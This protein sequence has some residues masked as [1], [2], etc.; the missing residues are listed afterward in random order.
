[1]ESLLQAYFE[2]PTSQN[3]GAY[4]GFT[5][6]PEGERSAN[7]RALFLFQTLGVIPNE[8]TI[9]NC[10]YLLE[11]PFQ[12]TSICGA[13]MKRERDSGRQLGFRFRCQGNITPHRLY[14]INPLHGTLLE[15]V[16]LSPHKVLRL[17]Q[18]YF[19]GTLV[20]EAMVICQVARRHAV[21]WYKIMR[22]LT[23][24]IGW[25]DF[26]PL[27]GPRHVV[28]VDE[29]FLFRAKYNVGRVL[30]TQR[31]EM[32]T[33]GGIDVVTGKRFAL[34]VPDRTHTTLTSVMRKF[35][36]PG[37][38]LFSDGW[39]AYNN[40]AEELGFASHMVIIHKV[41]FIFPPANEP[42]FWIRDDIMDPEVRDKNYVGPYPEGQLPFRV[43]TQSCERQWRSL[44][45][46]IQHG[47]HI[48]E[49]RID[50][51]IGSWMYRENILR[52]IPTLKNRFKRY[53]D[54]IRR[55]Y[56]GLQKTPI[57]NKYFETCNCT[58]CLN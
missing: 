38:H 53:F 28:Q 12:N 50:E 58:T 5:D 4:L 55:V 15:Q 40:C 20:T 34:L 10:D 33:F 19:D 2:S 3:C 39:S 9:V 37:T 36:R 1:M 42:P 56:P 46:Y 43:N 52:K 8:E 30:A 44:K 6:T 35:I 16:N 11:G 49:E 17:L 29:S 14:K 45:N 18:C 22:S 24:T 25:H 32:W 48:S 26:E 51:Y 27:G 13:V 31:N 41:H 47:G 54:D 7:E 23:Y 21:R 57:K